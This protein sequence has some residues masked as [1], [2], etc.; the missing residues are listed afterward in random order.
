MRVVGLVSVGL[1]SHVPRHHVLQQSSI[2]TV[3]YTQSWSFRRIHPRHKSHSP[4]TPAYLS[5]A[6]ILTGPPSDPLS[7]LLPTEETTSLLHPLSNLL[8]DHPIYSYSLTIIILSLILRS[9]IGIP[10]LLWQR[11]RIRRTRQ[12][13]EP[14]MK[15]MN[16]ELSLR[17]LVESRKKALWDNKFKAYEFY[18]IELKKQVSPV[19]CSS[20]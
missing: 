7:T 12:L 18:R 13:V 5:T 2:Y 4:F 1:R 11:S 9:A 3:Q 8:L 16:E 14:E 19:P 17:L 20:S 6:T 10:S 15:R